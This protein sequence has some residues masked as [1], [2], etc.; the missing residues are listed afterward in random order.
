MQITSSADFINHS[1]EPMKLLRQHKYGKSAH[2]HTHMYIIYVSIHI[3]AYAELYMS[4]HIRSPHVKPVK[5]ENNTKNNK[6]KKYKLKT[7]NGKCCP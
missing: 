7:F 3:D 5:S 4:A 1:N 2:T 6:N